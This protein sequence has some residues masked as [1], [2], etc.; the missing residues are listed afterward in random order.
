[1]AVKH[2]YL[3]VKNGCLCFIIVVGYMFVCG[4]VCVSFRF[5]TAQTLV[6]RFLQVSSFFK[7]EDESPVESDETK[8]Q[9][10]SC[11]CVCLWLCVCVCVCV[12]MYVF[13]SVAVCVCVWL[14]MCM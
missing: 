2:F 6:S 8:V 3:F 5:D 12:V 10:W 14:C 11:V 4:C 7:D 13:V 1:M 9:S